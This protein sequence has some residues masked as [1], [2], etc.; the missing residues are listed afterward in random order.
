MAMKSAREIVKER[1]SCYAYDADGNKI[2]GLI[3]AIDVDSGEYVV[4]NTDEN[5]KIVLGDNGIRSSTRFA[6]API[7]LV[8]VAEKDTQ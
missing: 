8:P 7:K 5:G 4:V 2:E 3:T 6:K 1:G